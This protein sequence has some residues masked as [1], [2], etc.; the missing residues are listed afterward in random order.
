MNP[1]AGEVDLVIDGRRR[2]M[3]LSLGALAALE[4]D[5]GA[6]SLADLAARF[7]GGDVRAAD[8][9]AVLHAGLAGGGHDVD[10]AAAEFEGGLPAAAR[11]AARLLARA[12]APL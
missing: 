3:R 10:V 7:D 6:G 8:V 5:L 9:L 4:S 11:A 1:L 12:F 2:V